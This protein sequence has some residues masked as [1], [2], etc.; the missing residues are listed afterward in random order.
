M[1]QKHLDFVIYEDDDEKVVFRFYPRQSHMHSFTE[2]PPKS[3]E[4]VYKVYYS[5][6][7]LRYQK[8]EDGTLE[9]AERV[10]YMYCDECSALEHLE[11]VI[12]HTLR[13][14][15]RRTQALSFGCPGSTWTILYYPIMDWNWENEED[16][17]HEILDQSLI[18]CE[19]FNNYSN[20]GYRFYMNRSTAFAFCDYLHAINQYM[21]ENSE[22][23]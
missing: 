16:D 23:I 20:L 18:T 21:L 10:F 22:P 9:Q 15:K 1:K 12:R 7:I 5:W 14:R 6:G 3:L 17:K 19:V 4:D 8:R 11:Y 13:Y 2:S